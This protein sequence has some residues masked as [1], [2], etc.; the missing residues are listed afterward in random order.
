TSAIS[1]G[2]DTYKVGINIPYDFTVSLNNVFNQVGSSFYQ[3]LQVSV[4]AYGKV[5]IGAQEV[6]RSGGS[7]WLNVRTVDLSTLQSN[8]IESAYTNN[9]LTIKVL[10]SIESYY[11]STSRLDGGRT[12]SY[13]D[14][15]KS[16]VEDCYFTI[17]IYEPTTGKSKECKLIFDDTIVNGVNV[18]ADLKF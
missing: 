12:I 2:T 16:I 17:R 18:P 10:K 5:E 13:H 1:S 9:V 7:N 4:V 3:N 15:V 14:K 8:I 6:Y 11:A